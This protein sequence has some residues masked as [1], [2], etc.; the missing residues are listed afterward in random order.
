[1]MLVPLLL[2]RREPSRLLRFNPLSARVVGF[3][4]TL[5]SR[6]SPEIFSQNELL[7]TTSP[8]ID[9]ANMMPNP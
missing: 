9:M 7:F 6:A 1:M 2:G 4:L 5:R 3:L 8:G